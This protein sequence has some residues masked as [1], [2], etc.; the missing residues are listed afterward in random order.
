MNKQRLKKD[1]ITLACVVIGAFIMAMNIKTFVSAGNLFPGGFTGL[2]VFIQR[3]GEK[4]FDV[5]LSYAVINIL[6]NAIPAIIG[7]KTIGKRF[8]IFSCIMIALTGFFVE[9]LPNS[10]LTYDPLLIAVFGGIF[11]G[12]GVSAALK[13]HAS[14]GGTDFIAIYMSRKLNAPAWNYILGLNAI[15]LLCAGYL[16]DWNQALYSIIFQFV[17]TQ[18]VSATHVRYKKMTMHIIT[19]KADELAEKLMIYTHHGI[20]RFEGMG[21]YSKEPKTLLYTVV[22]SEEIKEVIGFINCIDDKA[23]IN[24]MKTDT[25]EGRFYQEPID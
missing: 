4:F 2:T 9:V 8:T 17:S 25:V 6:L 23:F 1:S 15:L 5:Q 22:S 19:N 16:F 12:I 3:V 24:V 21:C 7:F 20:T 11:S 10:A 13:G 14:S 18:I